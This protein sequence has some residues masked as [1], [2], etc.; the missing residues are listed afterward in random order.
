[1]FQ[2]PKTVQ[3]PTIHYSEE[4]QDKRLSYDPG[5]G[6]SAYPSEEGV[7]SQLGTFSRDDYDDKDTSVTTESASPAELSKRYVEDTIVSHP[8]P[9]P[10]PYFPVIPSSKDR[11]KTNY[12]AIEPRGEAPP[13]PPPPRIRLPAMKTVEPKR[14]SLPVAVDDG[15]TAPWE[16]PSPHIRRAQEPSKELQAAQLPV[17]KR[18]QHAV[19]K[20]RLFIQEIDMQRERKV[21]SSLPLKKRRHLD[22]GDSLFARLQKFEVN[23]PPS[24]GSRYSS[25]ELYDLIIKDQSSPIFG[26]GV[27]IVHGYLKKRGLRADQ[28]AKELQKKLDAIQNV[29]IFLKTRKVP[30]EEEIDLNIVHSAI[31]DE[32]SPIYGISLLRLYKILKDKRLFNKAQGSFYLELN[33]LHFRLCFEKILTKAGISVDQEGYDAIMTSLLCCKSTPATQCS[34]LLEIL[35]RPRHASILASIDKGQLAKMLERVTQGEGKINFCVSHKCPLVLVTNT[36]L[37]QT[38]LY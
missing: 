10:L 23:H 27:A 19:I 15:A 9:P 8:E 7:L 13:P 32:A 30:L 29:E 4:V 25:R 18:K 5:S 3:Y 2:I 6:S 38:T 16:V 17:K 1:M 31:L 20:T 33:R 14:F 37:L 12:I 28:N 11:S 22:Q 21:A 34:N 26:L 35:Q 24:D 36:F